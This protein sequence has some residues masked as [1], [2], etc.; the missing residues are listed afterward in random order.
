MI[1][2]TR[3]WT[4]CAGAILL[5]AIP[6]S[7]VLRRLLDQWVRDAEMSHALVVPFVVAGLITR[8]FHRL[9]TLPVSCSGYGVPLALIGLLGFTASMSGA[10]LF[11]ASCSWLCSLAG[12]ILL[13]L[14]ATV[15]KEMLRPLSLLVFCLPRLVVLYDPLTNPLAQISAS[16]STAALR[17]FGVQA[18][19][20][21]AIVKVNGYSILLG[22]S[23]S[24]LRFLVPLLFVACLFLQLKPLTLGKGLL[25]VAG[26]VPLAVLAN[27]FRIGILI[28][29]A[30]GN[31]GTPPAAV[32]EI[33]GYPVF[34][35]AILALL[36]IV[37]RVGTTQKVSV[38]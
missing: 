18:T 15:F 14:G 16:L 33:L 4:A 38:S 23:C 27:S 31:N 24:G 25:V 11:I 1:A 32:H 29:L 10:G 5:L 17:I 36:T 13:I 7:V 22:E 8:R 28:T 37:S 6:Y 35:G 26:C 20:V 12:A 30:S 9:L 21:G 3:H 2:S 19:S 34:V